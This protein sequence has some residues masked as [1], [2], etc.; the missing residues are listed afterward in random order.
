MSPDEYTP[1]VA[2]A[3][4]NPPTVLAI[5]TPA[6]DAVDAFRADLEAALGHP[7]PFTEDAE[8]HDVAELPED[9]PVPYVLAIPGTIGPNG[10]LGELV[11]VGVAAPVP[12]PEPRCGRPYDQH[13]PTCYPTT[14]PVTEYI[15]RHRHPDGA[16]AHRVG[17]VAGHAE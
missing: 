16:R 1:A 10:E 14:E 13:P 3:E 17:H 6:S 8:W 9:E 5:V 2:I 15:G 7:V 4:A 11:A 12:T